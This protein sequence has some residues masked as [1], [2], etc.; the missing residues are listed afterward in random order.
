VR[1]AACVAALALL[2]ANAC[3][4]PPPVHL[5]P[6][7]AQELAAAV[8]PSGVKVLIVGIDGATFSVMDPMKGRLPAFE[9][10]MERGARG[11]LKSIKPMLSPA[12]WATMV[13][14]KNREE[15][16]IQ[17]FYVVEGEGDAKTRRMVGSADRKTLALW[18]LMRPFGKTAGFV[19]WWASWPAEEVP[20]WIVS[21][22]MTRERFTEWLSADRTGRLTWPDALTAELAPL[23]VD[24]MKPPMDELSAMADFT[25]AELAEMES[26]E[27]PLPH[28]WASVLKFSYCSQRSYEKI[29]LHQLAKGQPDLTGVYLIANDPVSHTFWHFY[30]PGAFPAGGVDPAQAAR[31]GKMVPGIY[32]HNDRY[33]AELLKAVDKDTVVIIV[34]DHGFQ[35]SHQLP[36]NEP[37]AEYAA[38]FEERRRQAMADGTVAVG[39]SGAH[40]IDG[41]FLAAGGP[42]RAGVKCEPSVLDIAPTVLALLGLPVADDM[43]GKVLEEIID[44]AFLREHP[45]RRIDSYEPLVERSKV[46][47]MKPAN[48]EGAM[49]MLRSL[50]YV[51]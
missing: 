30:E 1:R 39:Q 11:N 47:D 16:G 5:S 33:L 7:N 26:I 32:E 45:V 4:P 23:V 8:K 2:A 37:A 19:A 29:A 12:I 27:K 20:G 40:H 50:G 17:D 49:D 42:I 10:M 3:S 13:T 9:G 46:P 24:P 35:S 18:D 22:R 28:H 34:S 38:N 36:K 6:A 41:V 15:H 44:P 14:G 51:Q 25:P 48:D 21:D 31:L 43:P